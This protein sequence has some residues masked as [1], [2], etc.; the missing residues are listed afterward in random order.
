MKIKAA[1]FLT[2]GVLMAFALAAIAFFPFNQIA[3]ASPSGV[4]EPVQ[5]GRLSAQELTGT[6]NFDRAHSNIGF[7]ILH[8]GLAEVP[9]SF[10]DYTGTIVYDAADVTK[11]SV[12]FAAKMAS[13]NTG[14]EGRDK[15]LRTADFFEVEKFPEMTFKSTRVEKKSPN[16]FVAH[17]DF[18]LKGVTKQIALPFTVNGYLK[19]QRGNTKIGVSAVTTINRRD[20]N[21]TYGNTL[22]NGALALADDVTVNL[23]IEAAKPQPK[24]AASPAASP[25]E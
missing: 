16:Q 10:T 19:D 25:T 1:V 14:V 21:I 15:H 7:R 12:E 24:P 3:A 6:Y 8:M 9:G 18:T 13:V 4:Y 23:Q 20:Y 2:I 5:D 17:G 22:P 11:S